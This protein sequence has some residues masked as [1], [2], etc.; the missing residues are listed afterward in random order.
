LEGAGEVFELVIELFLY[1]GEL[2]GGEGGEI[3]WE[4]C[5]FDGLEEG[6]RGKGKVLVWPFGEDIL[7]V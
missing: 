3:N 1:G 5:E 2:L 7:G 6:G 4:G